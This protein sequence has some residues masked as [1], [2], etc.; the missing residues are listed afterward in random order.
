MVKGL[1]SVYEVL[2]IGVAG[3]SAY[4]AAVFAYFGFLCGVSGDDV[5]V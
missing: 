2:F 3:D 4:R 1:G 5:C